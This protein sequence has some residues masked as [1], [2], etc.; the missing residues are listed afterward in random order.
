MIVCM[1]SLTLGEG[2]I[3][4]TLGLMSSIVWPTERLDSSVALGVGAALDTR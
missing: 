1:S 4:F 3:M 2:S